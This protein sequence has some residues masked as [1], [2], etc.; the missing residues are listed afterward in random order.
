[1]SEENTELAGQNQNQTQESALESNVETQ[2]SETD[3]TD[4]VDGA[5]ETEVE[6]P[7]Y[8]DD[9]KKIYGLEKSVNKLVRKNQDMRS[10]LDSMNQPKPEPKPPIV[11]EDYGDDVEAY[12]RDVNQRQNEEFYE[13]KDA[14]RQNQGRQR[15]EHNQRAQEN[16]TRVQKDIPDVMQKITENAHLFT[17]EMAQAITTSEASL[18]ISYH[19]ATHPEE[20]EKFSRST[21]EAK[22]RMLMGYE[23]KHDAGTLIKKTVAAKVAPKVMPQGN[24]G[25]A[26]PIKTNTDHMTPEQYQAHYEK[27]R[28]GKNAQ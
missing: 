16:I 24:G 10:Q 2:N 12:N 8:T 21:P 17:Q 20:A 15:A 25:D 26:G 28:Y 5:V 18:E 27:Q 22:Q 14:E 6:K 7:E 11:R 1:M 19:L 3:S 23:M 13:K 4:A 9:Q